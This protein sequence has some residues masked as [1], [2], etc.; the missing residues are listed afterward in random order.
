VFDHA[1]T[2]LITDGFDPDL[3]RSMEIGFDRRNERTTFPLR[4]LYGNLAGFSGGATKEGQW[5][6]YKVYQG[7]RF[8]LNSRLTLPGDFGPMFDEQFPGYTC[9]NHSLLWNYDRVYPRV[10]E[11][12]DSSATV[13]GVEGF[14]ACLW[15]LMAGFQN[16]VALMGSYVSDIQQ[17]L[18]HRLGCRVVLFLDND[19][20]GRKA[21]FS[22]GER[23]WK[24][25][26][27]QVD[28]VPYP[29]VDVAASLRGEGNTQPDHYELDA[30]RE[31]VSKKITF[32]DHF[33]QSR[34]TGRW[35]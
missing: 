16:T 5:P 12:S 8:D 29:E 31:L 1:P 2:K 34:S 23:L 15:M 28:V 21:T 11:M 35:H 7:K 20:A 32:T 4:D 10:T 25:L 9:E 27:G 14:K 24:P 17:R 6:K 13:Y 26:K 33:N 19:E 30:V 3:L 18:L 22:V